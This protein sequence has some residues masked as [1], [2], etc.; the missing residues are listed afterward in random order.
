MCRL[1]LEK[2]ANI[3]TDEWKIEDL[4]KALGQLKKNKSRD[5]MGLANEIFRPEV[6]GHDLKESLLTMFNKIK[7]STFLP[8]F[9]KEKNI[10]AIP[11]GSGDVTNL[12]QERGIVIGSIFNNI[13]MK[14]I[15]NQKY[16]IVDENMSESQ[17]GSRKG[18][19]IRNN[20]FMIYGIL[21][22]AIQTKGGEV[23]WRVGLGRWIVRWI[24][25][26]TGGVDLEEDWRGVLGR[27][28]GEVDWG[29]EV[30]ARPPAH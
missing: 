21:N 10:S 20:N 15:Y 13:L 1:K 23:D 14:L 11:K 24:V 3:K 12:E 6:A 26:W 5:P 7:E 2:T 22:E 18:K 27:L 17:V 25:R 30:S 9:F 16:E 29:G 28:I 8:E 4:D 19:N